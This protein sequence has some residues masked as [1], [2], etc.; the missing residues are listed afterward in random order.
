MNSKKTDNSDNMKF[1]VIDEDTKLYDSI[2]E[3]S[4]EREQP[5]ETI[6]Q[7]TVAIEEQVAGFIKRENP[8]LYILT[9]CYGGI[10]YINYFIAFRRGFTKLCLCFIELIWLFVVVV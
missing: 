3:R 9:P 1:Q 2:L 4:L 6:V 5:L 7:S 10:C 8:K